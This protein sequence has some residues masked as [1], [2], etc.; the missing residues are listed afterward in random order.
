[1]EV[2]CWRAAVAAA[3]GGTR[4][5]LHFPRASGPVRPAA[6]VCDHFTPLRSG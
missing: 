2:V 3:G 4:C 5:L 6:L 1:M